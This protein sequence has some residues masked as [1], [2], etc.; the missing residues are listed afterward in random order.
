MPMSTMRS[1]SATPAGSRNSSAFA[2][3][4]IAVFAPMPM[5]SDSEAV[6]AKTGLRRIRRSL[7]FVP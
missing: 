3:V 1:G 2:T 4:K 6:M 7:P 5:A